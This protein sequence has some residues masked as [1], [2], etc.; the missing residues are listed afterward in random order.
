MGS[1]GQND[2]LMDLLPTF[3]GLEAA[4]S[5]ATE[6]SASVTP[7]TLPAGNADVAE[8]KTKFSRVSVQPSGGGEG[9][10][11]AEGGAGLY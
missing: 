8:K 7:A 5:V 9:E 6:P 1:V 10:G 2:P 11:A 3:Y 4:T